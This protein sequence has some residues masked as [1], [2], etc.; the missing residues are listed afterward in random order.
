MVKYSYIRIDANAKKMLDARLKKINEEDLRKIGVFRARVPQI[1]F[2]KF[3][4]TNTIF[5]SD[6][7]LKKMV[8]NKGGIRKC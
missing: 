5:I 6:A 3:L 2:T 8:R 1:E 7:E 4:F